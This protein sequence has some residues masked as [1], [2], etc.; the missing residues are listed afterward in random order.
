[1]GI[2]RELGVF[3]KKTYTRPG[4]PN[5]E[6]FFL[7]D[8][9]PLPDKTLPIEVGLKTL[10]P[11]NGRNSVRWATIGHRTPEKGVDRRDKAS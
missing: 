11:E 4:P 1:M 3:L 2:I 10:R 7:R 6:G 5:Q 9:N 8:T